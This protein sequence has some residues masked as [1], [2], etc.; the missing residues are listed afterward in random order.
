M[1]ILI[2]LHSQ[3]LPASITFEWHSM[4]SFFPE[5]CPVAIWPCRVIFTSN[6]WKSNRFLSRIFARGKF[7]ATRPSMI[8]SI[9]SHFK[10]AVVPSYKRAI[11]TITN[12]HSRLAK[13]LL[14]R[15]PISLQVRLSRST[16]KA[17]FTNFSLSALLGAHAYPKISFSWKRT[18]AGSLHMISIL[19][20]KSVRSHKV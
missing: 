17:C 20:G 19:P 18:K 11:T 4:L 5:D 1:S 7:Y 9:L 10:L 14:F 13:I 15:G 3:Q 2:H 12:F 8:E 16:S 6:E